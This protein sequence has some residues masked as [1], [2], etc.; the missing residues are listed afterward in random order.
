M[1][2]LGANELR[3]A[4]T[5]DG[6]GGVRG[7]IRRSPSEPFRNRGTIVN[8]TW[9]ERRSGERPNRRKDLHAIGTWVKEG[10]Q[11]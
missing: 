4:G 2:G 3:K 6:N 7:K 10:N 8:E 11:M 5:P 1:D 9:D